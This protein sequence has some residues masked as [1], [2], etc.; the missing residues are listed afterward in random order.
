MQEIGSDINK[1][2]SWSLANFGIAKMRATGDFKIQS[3]IDELEARKGK[4]TSVEEIN[5]IV[6]ELNDLSEQLFSRKL[7]QMLGY[8][9][10]GYNTQSKFEYEGS[11]QKRAMHVFSSAIGLRAQTDSTRIAVLSVAA[12]TVVGMLTDLRQIP[13]GIRDR[14][15]LTFEG[16]NN[17]QAQSLSLLQQ[18]GMNVPFVVD[19]LDKADK[20]SKD[21]FDLNF[22]SADTKNEGAKYLRD[23]IVTTLGNF[24]DSRIVNPQPHNLPKYYHDPRLRVVTAMGRFMASAHATLLPKLYRE[25]M[26]NGN[27]GMRYQA[28]STIAMSLLFAA[29]VNDL[30]DQL[31]YDDESPYIKGTRKRAQRNLYTSGLAGQY[32]KA[33]DMLV[34]LYPQSKTDITSKPAQWALDKVKDVSP[35]ASWAARPVQ[36]ALYAGEGKTDKAVKQIARATPVIGSFPVV[37]DMLSS[38]FKEK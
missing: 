25:Y 19:M 30:K 24:V 9:D 12:D 18:Y 1:S 31:S 21:L 15:F 17:E 23:N 2:N 33:I 16:L 37:A 10:T 14:A 26:M 7:F 34:P 13:K 27:V 6:D 38:P 11:N 4:A 8:D 5:K 36:A 3:K 32:E 35:V 22:L 28:F 29:L 20:Q